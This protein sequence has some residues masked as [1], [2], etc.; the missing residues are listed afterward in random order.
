MSTMGRTFSKY[1][2]LGN[3]FI[4]VDASDGWTVDEVGP[5][6]ARI[7]CARGTGVT[8]EGVVW[9]GRSEPGTPIRVVAAAADGSK[10]PLR[11]SAARCVAAHLART[12]RIATGRPASLDTGMGLARILLLAEEGGATR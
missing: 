9:V 2:T 7:L 3:D 5:K 12:K 10:P 6:P 8:A 4:I 11:D 1:E